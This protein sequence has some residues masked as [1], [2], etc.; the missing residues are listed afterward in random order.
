MVTR[1]VNCRLVL[2]LRV[3]DW[4]FYHL[5]LFV[6]LPTSIVVLEDYIYLG[7]C[8]QI[9]LRHIGFE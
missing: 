5:I 8:L 2:F 7:T 9:L 4:Q 3:V 1:S 6:L